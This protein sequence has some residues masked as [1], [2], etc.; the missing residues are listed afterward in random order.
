MPKPKRK[1]G[2]LAAAP[3]VITNLHVQD[4][5]ATDND[6][7]ALTGTKAWRKLTPLQAVYAK[8]QLAG[9]KERFTA[10]DRYAAGQSYTD[11]YDAAER[12]GKDSTQA[13]N[14]IRG[15]SGA[16]PGM[17]QSKAASELACIHSH[18]GHRDRQL[19]MLVCGQ[20]YWPSEAVRT[21]CG[22][23]RDTVMARFREALDS[24]CEAID[25]VRDRPSRVDMARRA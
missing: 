18:L 25:A 21:V 8:N 11:A 7:K 19:I 4:R 1:T 13:L 23:Y 17:A 10:A 15:G 5:P 22:D 24:L 9:G 2:Y 6:G 14:A 16:S 3:A 20:G 12:P